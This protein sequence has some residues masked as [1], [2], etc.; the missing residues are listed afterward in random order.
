[1]SAKSR[2]CAAIAESHTDKLIVK[3]HRQG[4]SIPRIARRIGRPGDHE[5]VKQALER[6]KDKK[7]DI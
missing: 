6:E 1:M 3:L 4:V 5:R 2:R 7:C